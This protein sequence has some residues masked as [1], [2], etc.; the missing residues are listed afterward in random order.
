[1]RQCVPLVRAL[2]FGD[3]EIL[4]NLFQ[5]VPGSTSQLHFKIAKWLASGQLVFLTVVVVV[6]FLF[7]RFVTCV[8][9]TLKSPNR[10]RSIK[11]V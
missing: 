11:Y 6:V 3:P 10:E 5:V 1:M 4:S 8:S 2:A 7:R 9:L